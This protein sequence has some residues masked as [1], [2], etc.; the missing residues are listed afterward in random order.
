MSRPADGPPWPRGFQRARTASL[1]DTIKNRRSLRI[2]KGIQSVPAGSLSYESKQAPQP[3]DP[4]EEAIL[5][6]VAGRMGKFTLPDRPFEDGHGN[7]ILGS[8]NIRFLRRAAGSPDNAQ[9]T[10]F[11]MMN[12]SG[13]YFLDHL[14]AD[15][16]PVEFSPEALLE[17]AE[18]VKVRVLDHRLDFP[19]ESPWYLDSNRFVSNL[20]GSTI[21]VP[22]VDMT[23]Q[24][25]NGLMYTFTGP[26]GRRM[27]LLDELNGYRPAGCKRWVDNG[28]LNPS[29]PT[30]LSYAVSHFYRGHVEPI[31][32]LQNQVLALQAMGLGGWIHA[33]FE[34]FALLG[35]P[36]FGHPDNRGLDFRWVVPERSPIETPDLRYLANP[37]GRDGLIQAYCP[38]YYTTM[39]DAVD[40]VID[41]KYREGSNYGDRALMREQF[42]GD[43]GDKYMA[44]VP[45]Y[46]PEV[47]EITKEVCEYFHDRYGRFPMQFDAMD[48]PGIW[49][50]AHHLDREY[51]D[52]LFEDA[53]SDVHRDHD[54]DWHR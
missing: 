26:P 27:A 18:S 47:I 9:N 4:L 37:V 3:L 24:L 49:L 52:S 36:L 43:L 38:P 50:Q 53:Y 11:F 10:Y 13:T 19:R 41:L 46:A 44:E 7:R 16:T 33:S 35:H 39:S 54:D 23:L 29:L 31:L 1:F 51:Y 6:A 25:I 12:D 40:A 28:Y 15:P 22:V 5:I 45:R 20:P 8:P 42:K 34:N 14:H 2:S 30:D 21:F 32:L 48:V 17:Y